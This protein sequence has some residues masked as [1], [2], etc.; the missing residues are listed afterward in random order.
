MR[1]GG[2]ILVGM[3]VIPALG[4]LVEAVPQFVLGGADMTLSITGRNLTGEVH[5]EFQ[6]YERGRNNVDRYPRGQVF[7]VSLTAEY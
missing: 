5:E 3:G 4:H 6:V 1:D 7:S 2:V